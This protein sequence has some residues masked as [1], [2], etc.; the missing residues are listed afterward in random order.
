MSSGAERKDVND[1]PL[2]CSLFINYVLFYSRVSE[3]G[4]TF[5]FPLSWSRHSVFF[6]LTQIFSTK[7]RLL[8]QKFTRKPTFYH[9]DEINY[10]NYWLER[11]CNPL[12]GRDP[13]I[14]IRSRS[15][16][17]DGNRSHFNDNNSA[18]CDSCGFS[19]SFVWIPSVRQSNRSHWC[20]HLR[21]ESQAPPT[22]FIYFYFF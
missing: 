17:S 8:R 16:T 14:E 18:I 7:L 10:W 22:I 13:L 3:V 9:I 4:T 1:F 15:A 11:L 6:H 5:F 2:F 19:I 20:F 12:L 21:L